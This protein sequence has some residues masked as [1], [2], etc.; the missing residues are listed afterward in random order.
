MRQLFVTLLH[1]KLHAL[2]SM[3]VCPGRNI[4]LDGLGVGCVWMN[5]L[6]FCCTVAPECAGTVEKYLS[7]TMHASCT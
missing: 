3:T 2:T 6:R 5:I 1:V 4:M 7:N